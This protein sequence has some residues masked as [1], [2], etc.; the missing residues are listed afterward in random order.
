MTQL[1]LKFTR[2]QRHM[3]WVCV[4]TS[5]LHVVP[6]WFYTF[7]THEKAQAFVDMACEKTH[8]MM[9]EI[10]PCELEE[11]DEALR[12]FEECMKGVEDAYVFDPNQP[13]VKF[14]RP[15]EWPDVVAIDE[16]DLQGE[17]P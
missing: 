7:R 17:Q 13:A 4:G 14:R 15:R 9:W 12:N 6:T 2:K 8:G 16:L 1:E 3:A 11:P 5:A 10:Y